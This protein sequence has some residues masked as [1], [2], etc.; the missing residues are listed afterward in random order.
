MRT[1]D[2]PFKVSVENGLVRIECDGVIAT[3]DPAM[4]DAAG[5]HMLADDPLA[6]QGRI[7]KRLIESAAASA[8][9]APRSRP[10]LV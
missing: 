7:G 4:A 10:A 3:I 6:I 1:V 2:R 9:K 8:A 5:R